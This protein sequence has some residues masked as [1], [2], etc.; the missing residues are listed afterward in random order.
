MPH[1]LDT[2]GGLDEDCQRRRAEQRADDNG[3]AVHAVGERLR[4]TTRGVTFVSDWRDSS[5]PQVSCQCPKAAFGS[6]RMLGREPQSS[7]HDNPVAA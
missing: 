4:G 6:H 2:R 1:L 3:Q 5:K 7:R